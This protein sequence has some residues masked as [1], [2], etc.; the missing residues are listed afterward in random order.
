MARVDVEFHQ[1]DKPTLNGRLWDI[2]P[3]GAGLHFDHAV[4]LVENDVGRLVL[5][6][7]YS[8]EVLEIEAQVCWVSTRENSSL[9]GT[10]FGSLLPKK[11]FLDPYI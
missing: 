4:D 10:V 6:Q 2:S 5:R 9:V 3:G 11:S 1:P 8:Q 7:S